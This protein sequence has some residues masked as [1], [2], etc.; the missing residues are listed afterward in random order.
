MKTSLLLSLVLLVGCS[1]S[2]V[3]APENYTITETSHECSGNS[4]RIVTR[5]LPDTGGGPPAREVTVKPIENL[6]RIQGQMM[7]MADTNPYAEEEDDNP[8]AEMEKQDNLLKAM[9]EAVD[10]DTP[11]KCQQGDPLCACIPEH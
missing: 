8:Y 9:K 6:P 4:C 2:P 7:G 1:H 11:C 5:V 3:K 10:R